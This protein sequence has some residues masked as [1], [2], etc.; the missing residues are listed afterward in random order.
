ERQ[1]HAVSP[2]QERRGRTVGQALDKE[3]R[4]ALFGGR[5]DAEATRIC[6]Y[7]D[8]G[9]WWR[10]WAPTAP[11]IRGNCPSTALR[12]IFPEARPYIS[13]PVPSCELSRW[14][15]RAVP[16]RQVTPES[17]APRSVQ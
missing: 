14:T 10:V 3:A 9:L 17:G 13:I 16:T 2:S 1:N 11:A 8:A 5:L 15:V 12:R 7:Q 6:D 4:S